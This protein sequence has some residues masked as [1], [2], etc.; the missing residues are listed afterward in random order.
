M[1]LNKTASDALATLARLARPAL[2]K[3]ASER[4]QDTVA[5]CKDAGLDE[6]TTDAMVKT[7]RRFEELSTLTTEDLVKRALQRFLSD[8]NTDSI[9]LGIKRAS[10]DDV[11]IAATALKLAEGTKQA[12]TP[13]DAALLLALEKRAFVGKLINKGLGMAQRG[14]GRAGMKMTGGK[15][16]GGLLQKGVQ[17]GKNVAGQGLRQNR[18]HLMNK[19]M[20][21]GQVSLRAS[22]GAERA[23]RKGLGGWV[24]RN[25]LLTAGAAGGGGYIFGED[26]G[27]GSGQQVGRQEAVQ[28]MLDQGWGPQQQGMFSGWFG[29]GGGGQNQQPPMQ[30]A[31]YA[32]MRRNMRYQQGL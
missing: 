26:Q 21:S 17:R 28:A 32:N 8:R 6:E 15:F 18:Q 16:G 20:T 24:N 5:F 23:T 3:E 1:P 22:Q 4:V 31:E 12:G 19:G 9:F 11:V 14:M 10:D 7:S 13:D 29:G 30:G 25:P 2:T 27:Y